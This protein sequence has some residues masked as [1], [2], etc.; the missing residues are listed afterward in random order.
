MILEQ[1][2]SMEAASPLKGDA[3]QPERSIR[4]SLYRNRASAPTET[5]SSGTHHNDQPQSATPKRSR[6]RLS[7]S[8]SWKA[9]QTRS[10]CSLVTAVRAAAT[11]LALG[12]RVDGRGALGCEPCQPTFAAADVE[13]ALAVEADER[14]EA[15]VVSTAASSRLSTRS[16]ACK[17]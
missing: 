7:A 14:D 17:P 9:K 8:A 13:H 5:G 11:F 3:R 16:S 10:R 15:A 2:S 6:A 12:S 4:P 1:L